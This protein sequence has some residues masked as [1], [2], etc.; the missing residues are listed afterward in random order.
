MKPTIKLYC[1]YKTLK[2]YALVSSVQ[3]WGPAFSKIGSAPLIVVPAILSNKSYPYRTPSGIG[4]HGDREGKHV[5][6]FILL[7]K[8]Y[9]MRSYLTD[10]LSVYTSYIRKIP[11]LSLISNFYASKNSKFKFGV[12]FSRWLNWKTKKNMTKGM[13]LEGPHN[14]FI[15]FTCLWTPK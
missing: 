14:L 13:S 15:L 1:H 8:P 6:S 4:E 7:F 9:L 3:V 12:D 5:D 10:V 11:K 2:Y